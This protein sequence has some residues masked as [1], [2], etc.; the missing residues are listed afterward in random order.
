MVLHNQSYFISIS[1]GSEV[2]VGLH[3]VFTP[4]TSINYF[5]AKIYDQHYA[6]KK[7]NSIN[8]DHPTN[9]QCMYSF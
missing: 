1:Y 2:M 9:E 7:L 8:K 6:T 4:M 5:E 3:E